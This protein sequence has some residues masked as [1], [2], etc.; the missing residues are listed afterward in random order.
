MLVLIVGMLST[1]GMSACS[2]S[3]GEDVEVRGDE[4]LQAKFRQLSESGGSA[5]LA[6]LTDFEWNSVYVFPEG[7]SAGQV[8]KATGRDI[9]KENFYS[10]AGNLLVFMGEDTPT[11]AISVVPDL[12]VTGG[13]ARWTDQVRLEARGTARPA[14][15][16][17]DE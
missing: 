3:R 2:N 15:L 11:V 8:A 1:V 13:R 16:Q 10:E 7:A 17:L 5:R 6:D 14:L 4:V 12:L 9:L